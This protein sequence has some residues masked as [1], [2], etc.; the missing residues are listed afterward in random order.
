[1]GGLLCDF[2]VVLSYEARFLALGN[3]GA[4]SMGR[5]ALN[6]ILVPQYARV[7]SGSGHALCTS[8]KA[9]M[10]ADLVEVCGWFP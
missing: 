9:K 2:L 5:T 10:V 6:T 4:A 8:S 1:M 7:L 3:L